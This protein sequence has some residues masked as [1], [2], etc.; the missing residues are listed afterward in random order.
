MPDVLHG[1]TYALRPEYDATVAELGAPPRGFPEECRFKWPET[2]EAELDA[3]SKEIAEIKRDAARAVAT[4][5]RDH[6]G[7]FLPMNGDAGE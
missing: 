2:P 5:A 7:R 1:T 6:S 4:R 3:L